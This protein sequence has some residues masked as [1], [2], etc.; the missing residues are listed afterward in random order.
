MKNPLSD[1]VAIQHIRRGHWSSAAKEVTQDKKLN[2]SDRDFLLATISLGQ[3]Q[4]SEGERLLRRACKHEGVHP[5]VYVNLANLLNGQG[6]YAES[7]PY[8]KNAYEAKQTDEAFAMP[9]LTALLDSARVDEA[10]SVIERFK[11]LSS[12]S[13]KI[14]IAESACHRQRGDR[15]QAL[16]ILEELND[17]YPSDPLVQ[18]M[19]ADT[20]GET[21]SNRAL[22]LYQSAIELYGRE[23]KGA[24]IHALRWNM[25]LH[26]LRTRQF[27]QGWRFYQSGLVREVGSLSRK[28]PD[29]LYGV[30]VEDPFDLASVSRGWKLLVVEQGIGDQVLFLSALP[31][32]IAEYS[33]VALVCE[34]RL[35]RIVN[36]SFP[37]VVTIDP[38]ILEHID[39]IR[40]F[41]STFIPI[42][43]LF[44]RYRQHIADFVR[45]RKPYLVVDKSKY[46]SRRAELLSVAAGRPIVGISW[47]GG[48]WENQQRNKSITLD[49]WV[50][51]TKKN[52]LFVNLQYGDVKHELELLRSIG[53]DVVSYPDVD[54]KKDLDDWMTI[55][56]ACDGIVSISTALVHFAGAIGQKVA[57]VLPEPQG[58]WIWGVGDKASLVYSGVHIFRPNSTESTAQLMERVSKVIVTQ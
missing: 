58:P 23:K 56:A 18:R 1:H 37:S 15:G 45:A 55:A 12:S 33:K 46:Q 22:A 43:N 36:R 41:G 57:M 47:K 32:A 13:K 11:Q 40:F 26:L 16:A 44:A 8:A 24:N 7:L 9:Y 28:L 25:S 30:N 54:Y 49:D 53:V 48:F 10:L 52:A 6:R 14:A 21:D 50:P 35:A 3:G 4:I 31:D 51:L 20:I 17:R 2:E 34:S 42:G 19:L 39:Q 5:D 27:S 38:G 29:Q